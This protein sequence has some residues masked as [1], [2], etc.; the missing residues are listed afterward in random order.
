LAA[1]PG[2]HRIEMRRNKA[3]HKQAG[4][5]QSGCSNYR[6]CTS[7][8][9]CHFSA[10]T[11]FVRFRIDSPFLNLMKNLIGHCVR[12]YKPKKESHGVR[13]Q[14]AALSSQLGV[15]SSQ[16]TRPPSCIR[17]PNWELWT[18]NWKLEG[19]SKLPHSKGLAA[20]R[21]DYRRISTRLFLYAKIR[22]SRRSETFNFPRIEVI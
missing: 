3:G 7:C 9:Q 17:M 1:S 2:L 14:A 12:G 6:N 18:E 16:F 21:A 11:S 13:Q 8:P 15:S 22:S 19:G 4:T 20:R 5:E 10:Q